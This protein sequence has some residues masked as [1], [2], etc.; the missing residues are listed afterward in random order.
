MKEQNKLG[1]HLIAKRKAA[2]LSQRDVGRAMGWSTA[3]FI[4]NWERGISYP[5]P[6]VIKKL[7]RLYG[8]SPLEIFEL[9]MEKS[10]IKHRFTLYRKYGKSL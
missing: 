3:Q 8:C 10:I 2:K 5:P 1:E 4:S 9:S 7:A 6:E